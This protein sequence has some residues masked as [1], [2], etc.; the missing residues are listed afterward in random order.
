MHTYTRTDARA[1]THTH[2]HTPHTHTHGWY[3]LC[4]HHAD[5]H[6]QKNQL[7]ARIWGRREK[8]R[9]RERERERGREK[10][11]EGERKGERKG[12]QWRT[13]PVDAPWQN[14]RTHTQ[15]HTRTAIHLKLKP[16]A[17]NAQPR[18]TNTVHRQFL[19]HDFPQDQ[20]RMSQHCQQ[21]YK[22]SL[23]LRSYLSQSVY[24]FPK[25]KVKFVLAFLANAFQD[26]GNFWAALFTYYMSIYNA[27]TKCD[28]YSFGSSPL[29]TDVGLNLQHVRLY[30]TDF[31]AASLAG[32]GRGGGSLA[33]TLS[34]RESTTHLY[35]QN[36]TFQMHMITDGQQHFCTALQFASSLHKM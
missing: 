29:L 30:D 5:P 7:K 33:T 21:K 31:L 12:A 26:L 6:E 32:E 3:T 25:I 16:Q 14:G 15:H 17:G 1:C 9:E 20:G 36:L 22:H 18:W 13:L 24:T 27:K 34:L 28:F 35:S 8:G 2:T 10:G 19:A 11:R 23:R 4:A